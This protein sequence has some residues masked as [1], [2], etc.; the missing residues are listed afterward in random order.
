MRHPFYME[1]E[2]LK[3]LTFIS[4]SSNNDRAIHPMSTSLNKESY[5]MIDQRNQDLYV[6]YALVL[7]YSLL[8]IYPL[9]KCYIFASKKEKALIAE[10]FDEYFDTIGNLVVVNKL[11]CHSR[12]NLLVMAND[13]V[14]YSRAFV[15]I[16]ND[17]GIKTMYVQHCS[18]S[19]DFPALDFTYCFLDGEE[20]LLKYMSKNAPKGLVYLSG[21]SRFDIIKH[22]RLNTTNTQ[23]IG[24]A[25]N[26]LDD[27]NRVRELCLALKQMR[28]STIIIRPHP[29]TQFDPTWY[30]E[31]G[32]E[33]SDSKREN[34]FEFLSKVRYVISGEC[35]IHLDAALMNVCAI[36][37]NMTSGNV[38]DVYEFIKNGITTR[39][40]TIGQL[41]AIFEKAIDLHIEEVCP[42]LSW[43][44][45]AYSTKYEGHIGEM[46]AEFIRYEQNGSIEEFDKKYGFVERTINGYAVKVFDNELM[47]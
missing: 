32:F 24:V 31:N 8:L 43:Y 6:P 42:K 37:Y 4:I 29:G 21:N 17:L 46:L 47:S 14:S 22:Y 35:G 13:H 36:Y 3:S 40:D 30:M 28:K 25:L 19:R 1:I 27:E 11:L 33:Y 9:L 16:A 12:V 5:S 2:P 45:A 34:P 26:A 18:V 10:W 38:Q 39:V 20:S 41:N 15:R 23:N 7:L 44:N